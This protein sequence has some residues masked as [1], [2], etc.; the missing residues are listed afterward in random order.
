MGRAICEMG[1]GPINVNQ[2][3]LTD[4]N[5]GFISTAIHDFSWCSWC[6]IS[7]SELKQQEPKCS[8]S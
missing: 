7:T 6:H 3:A 5:E 4:P 8:S 2:T 1:A